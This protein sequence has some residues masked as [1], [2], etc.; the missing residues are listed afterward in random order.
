VKVLLAIIYSLS[1]LEIYIFPI[2]HIEGIAGDLG[3]F[4]G[5]KS[6]L[7]YIFKVAIPSLTYAST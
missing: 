2:R 4:C 1:F 6:L 3:L 7:R 5:V